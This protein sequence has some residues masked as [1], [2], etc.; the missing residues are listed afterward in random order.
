MQAPSV[1]APIEIPSLPEQAAPEGATHKFTLS[2]V[3]FEGNSVLSADELNGLATQYVGKEITLTQ[4]F[5][6][7]GQVTAA[8]RTR[9][10]ILARAIVPTQRIANGE[11]HIRIVEGFIDKVTVQG[12]AGGAKALLEEHGRNIAASKP[13]TSDVMERELL[14]AQDLTGFK[15]RS[16]L[17]PS[18]TTPGGADLTLLVERKAYDAYLAVDNRG[19][20]YLGPLEI[21]GAAYANDL[22]GTAGRLGI[23]AVAS[24]NDGPEVAF[25][26]I[27]FDQ[28]LT[29]DGLR[30]YTSLSHTRTEPGSTLKVLNSKGRSTTFEASLSYPF[31]RSRDLN[32]V[33]Q[34]AWSAATSSRITTSSIRSSTTTSARSMRASM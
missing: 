14:L 20:E 10:Y 4:V 27:S 30:L 18:Q 9:G 7:A 24:P 6:L 28:P 31:I 34:A 26:A 12:D 25:G 21:T 13:L 16:V 17:T 1:G 29:A 2:N 23:V 11:L 15:I 5:E 22:F 33:F 19:S 32:L 8:Y 3:V